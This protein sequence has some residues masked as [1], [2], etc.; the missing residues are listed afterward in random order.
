M[1]TH[2]N[3][4]NRTFL[5]VLLLDTDTM[6]VGLASCTWKIDLCCL[7]AGIPSFYRATPVWV[8]KCELLV[9]HGN[10]ESKC[11]HPT[12]GIVRIKVG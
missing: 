5:A 8:C 1:S 4:S 10:Q 7:A 11:V 3:S 12:D 2:L 6:D 9:S